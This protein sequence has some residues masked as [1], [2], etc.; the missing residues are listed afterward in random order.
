MIMEILCRRGQG[1]ICVV[2]AQ[3]LEQ[4]SDLH[5][6]LIGKLFHAYLLGSRAYYLGK[7]EHQDRA[8]RGFIIEL[9]FQIFRTNIIQQRFDSRSIPGMV[10][11]EIGRGVPA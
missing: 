2:D 10:N 5:G 6:N 3:I 4:G 9:P 8:Q 1:G 7:K 11:K